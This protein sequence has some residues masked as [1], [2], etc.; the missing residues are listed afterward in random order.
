MSP[1]DEK[2]EAERLLAGLENG[3]LSAADAVIIAEDLDPVLVYVIVSFLRAVYPASDPAASSV[4]ERVVKLTSGSPAV[5]KKYREGGQDP[6]SAWFESEHPYAD[7][8][9]R[10]REMIELIVDKLES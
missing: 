2:Q 10:G 3:G 6:I 1:I 7:L 4:L 5:I 9:G 8:R